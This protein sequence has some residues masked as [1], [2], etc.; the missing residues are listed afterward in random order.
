MV[1]SGVSFTR[2][3]PGT[4][5]RRSNGCD[6][7]GNFSPTAS[8]K[9]LYMPGGSLSWYIG[10]E[11]NRGVFHANPTAFVRS[12]AEGYTRSGPGSGFAGSSAS[13]S[14]GHAGCANGESS[15]YAG[16]PDGK[17]A[18][19]AAGANDGHWGGVDA[20]SGTQ[21]QIFREAGHLCQA[22]HSQD[23]SASRDD[24]L[25]H[26]RRLD[27]NQGFRSLYGPYHGGVNHHHPG[28]RRL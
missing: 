19:H 6:G 25:L 8:T 17:S 20:G 13:E 15:S 3:M 22:S 21:A 27:A 4:T 16:R 11:A 24:G 10:I 12:S 9:V 14:T 7:R 1:R 2:C 5:R 23:Q 28:D 26:D 18:G